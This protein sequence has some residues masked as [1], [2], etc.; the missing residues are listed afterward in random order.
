MLKKLDALE[1]ALIE[2]KQEQEIE[3]SAKFY[4]DR[5]FS[6]MSELR[7]TV[8]ELETLVAKKHWPMPTYAEMLYSVV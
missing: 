7:F 1:A 4:R 2:V 8:D 3:A 5:V 6:A